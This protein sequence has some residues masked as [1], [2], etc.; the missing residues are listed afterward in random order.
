MAEITERALTHNPAEL[1]RAVRL[2]RA[3]GCGIA[4]DDVGAVSYSL[5]LLPFLVPDVIKLDMSLVQ[6]WPDADQARILTAVSAYAERTGATVPA[7]GIET[8]ARRGVL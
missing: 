5:A 2:M 7:E 8:A 4:L 1:L 6:A 3:C